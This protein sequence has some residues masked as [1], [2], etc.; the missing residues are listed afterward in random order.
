MEERKAWLDNIRWMTIVLVVIYHVFYYYHNIGVD[1]MFQGLAANPAAADAKAA[2]TPVAVFLYFVYPWFMMLLFVV[3]GIVAG[4]VLQKKDMKAFLAE[5]VNKLLVPSTLGILTLQWVGGYLISFNYF[6]AEQKAGIPGPVRYLIYCATGIGALWF[7]QVLFVC[8]LLLALIKK[9]D[10]NDRLTT[11]GAKTTLPVLLLLTVVVVGAAQLFNTPI[12]TYRMCLYPVAFL[13]GYYIFSNENVQLTVKT[14][15]PLFLV[16]GI[17]ADIAYIIKDYGTYYASN[18]VQN[19]PVAIICAWFMVL[20][21]L[22]IAQR[23][24]NFSNSFTSYM[25]KAGW[26]IYVIHINV[27]LLTNT[28]LKP[29]TATLPIG[30]IYLIELVAAFGVSIPLWEICRRIPAI[31]WLLL[32]IRRKKHVQG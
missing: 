25:S 1:P 26:G 15:A 20:G 12:T 7:C 31:R 18:E 14:Y 6:T 32:G 19:D 21:I 23:V 5:R 22:G 29:F 24:C 16:I 9:I 10:K 13:L 28:L 27:M 4:I 2:V 8:C 30:I 3:S 17:A 11:L